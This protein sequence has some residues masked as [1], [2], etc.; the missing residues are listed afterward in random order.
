MPT[1]RVKRMREKLFNTIPTITAEYVRQ[2][3]SEPRASL[4]VSH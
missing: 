4:I 2:L 3:E 1:P